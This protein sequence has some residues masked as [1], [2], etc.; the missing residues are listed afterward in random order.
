MR[1]S[2]RRSSPR[3]R[4]RRL[5]GRG[6][7]GSVYS[8]LLGGDQ[9]E[10]D[11]DGEEYEL[12]HAGTLGE[13]RCRLLHSSRGRDSSPP[14]HN[15]DAPTV[16]GAG[17]GARWVA[18][19][20]RGP[21]RRPH[22]GGAARRTAPFAAEGLLPTT[23]V[24][25]ARRGVRLIGGSPPRRAQGAV[26]RPVGVR[27]KRGRMSVDRIACRGDVD[28]QER[29]SRDRAEF[30]RRRRGGRRCRDPQRSRRAGRRCCVRCRTRVAGRRRGPRR[31]SRR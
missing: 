2:G 15:V 30:R 5:P 3:R 13:T 17:A 10:A 9:A 28:P 6:E 11:E 21:A 26:R 29:V 1:R 16:A 14:E 4:P 22:S 25:R 19:R 12:L 7:G 31:G 8:Q 20:L 27:E 23:G 18:G 24:T